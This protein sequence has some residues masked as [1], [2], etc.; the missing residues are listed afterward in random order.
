[1][2]DGTYTSKFSLHLSL[3]LKNQKERKSSENPHVSLCFQSLAFK[4]VD[5][6]WLQVCVTHLGPSFV[7]SFVCGQRQPSNLRTTGSL[8][9]AHLQSHDWEWLL[10]SKNCIEHI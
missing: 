2:G 8:A 1:M 6:S 10:K 5:R 3:F 4:Y 7:F 9:L